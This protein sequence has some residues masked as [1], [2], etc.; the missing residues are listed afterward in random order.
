MALWALYLL[1]IFGDF[2]QSIL[3]T[4]T[5]I[6]ATSLGAS[7][8]LVGWIGSAYGLAYCLMPALL[9]R[10]G[11]KIPRKKSLIYA[12]FSQISL[13]LFLLVIIHVVPSHSISYWLFL[14]NLLCGVAYGF[15]WPSIE[16]YIS[17]SNPDFKAHEHAISN[18]CLSWSIGYALGPVFGGYLTDQNIVVVFVLLL[19]LYSIGLGVILLF[20]PRLAVPSS[21]NKSPEPLLT[22]KSISLSSNVEIS[23]SIFADGKKSA[24]HRL[25][26][27]M[28]GTLF[29]AIACKVLLVYFPNYAVSPAGLNWSGTVYGLV[30]LSFGVGRTI[31]FI[32]GRYFSK[33]F[34]EVIQAILYVSILLF[35]IPLLKNQFLLIGML[36]IIGFFIGKIYYVSLELLLKYEHEQKGAKAGL[37]ES[38]IGFG[39]SITPFIAG[40]L[41]MMSL[42]L[43]FVFFGVVGIGFVLLQSW[44]HKRTQILSEVP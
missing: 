7:T 1:A 34:E 3:L 8:S 43:P 35:F 19:V 36:A 27:V 16:A 32:I 2:S 11:D 30:I 42:T 44:F 9:G 22:S 29:Y 40:Y 26:L 39:G 14:G 25:I 4:S 17:E 31:Y 24:N 37:F 23:K 13:A 18:F 38:A 5:I 33:R 15:Y 10:L 12:A 41:A 28:S 20:L 6:Y 21:V